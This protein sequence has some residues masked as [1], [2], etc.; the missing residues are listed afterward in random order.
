MGRLRVMLK[1]IVLF[2]KTNRLFKHVVASTEQLFCIIPDSVSK[3][4]TVTSVHV[5][6]TAQTNSYNVER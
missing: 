1:K 2:S 4:M 5:G 3:L 6:H